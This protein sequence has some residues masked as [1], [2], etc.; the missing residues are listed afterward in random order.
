LEKGRNI[1]PDKKV[2]VMPNWRRAFEKQRRSPNE[3][4]HFLEEIRYGK[5]ELAL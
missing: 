5:I 4:M 3:N 2:Q 1:G